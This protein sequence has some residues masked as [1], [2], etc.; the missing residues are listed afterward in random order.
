M[1]RAHKRKVGARRYS[2][3]SKESLEACMAKISNAKLS[4][5]QEEVKY[6]IPRRTI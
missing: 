4:H 2:D 6:K 1:T 3:F 5:R